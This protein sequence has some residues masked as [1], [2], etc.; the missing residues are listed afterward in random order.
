MEK[1]G[2]TEEVE[3]GIERRKWEREWAGKK[4]ETNVSVGLDV[5]VV[6]YWEPHISAKPQSFTVH[7]HGHTPD[8]GFTSNPYQCV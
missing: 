7:S 3:R 4:R 8:V 1:A 6:G 2:T 5:I